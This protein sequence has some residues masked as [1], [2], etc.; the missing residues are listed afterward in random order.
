MI[1]AVIPARSGSKGVPNK[2][3]RTIRGIPLLARAVRTAKAA[4]VDQVWVSTDSEDYAWTARAYGADGIVQRP[5]ELAEDVPTE[6]VLEHA[7]KKI[8]EVTESER[9]AAS[10]P[11]PM[12]PSSLPNPY[13]LIQCTTPLFSEVDINYAIEKYKR[14]HCKSLVSVTA[15]RENP[16]WM[17]EMK[18]SRLEPWVAD[19][20]Q[21]KGEWGVRQ[22]FEPLYRPNGAIYLVD[23][24]MFQ[25]QKSLFISPMGHHIMPL[26]RSWEVDE[27]VDFKI[28]EALAK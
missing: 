8:E 14:Y 19:S 23:R 17:F 3:M 15:C 26:E 6:L 13:L 1:I 20:D 2:N 4:N 27:E 11:V 18:S 5:P 10:I 7:M 22:N 16:Y 9:V 21:L 24:E 28:L 12:G 25:L